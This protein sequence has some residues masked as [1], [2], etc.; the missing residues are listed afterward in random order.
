MKSLRLL[1]VA[2]AVSWAVAGCGG[3]SNPSLAE[4]TDA[5]GQVEGAPRDRPEGWRSNKPGARYH[6][7]D[8]VRTGAASSARLRMAHGGG[9]LAMG[10]RSL[11][12]FGQSDGLQKITLATGEAEI[13]TGD[14][15][16]VVDTASGPAR[17]GAGS[18][19]R[20]HRRGGETH[21]EVVVGT[22]RIEREG[23]EA[24]ALAAGDRVDVSS[25]GD[26][27]APAPATTADAGGADAKMAETP[28]AV[29]PIDAGAPTAP[30]TDGADRA[31][32]PTLHGRAVTIAAPP[33]A[34]DIA[35]PAGETSRV[36][37]ARP[38]AYVRLTVAGLCDGPAVIQVAHGRSRHYYRGRDSVPVTFSHG[39]NRYRV[40]CQTDGA[41]VPAAD[42]ARSRGTVRV[43]RD[44]GRRRVKTRA[45][46]NSVDIDGRTYR[47]LYQNR[48]PTIRFVWPDAPAASK[49][50]LTIT[51]TRGRARNYQAGKPR[52]T[53]PSGKL[54]EGSYRVRMAIPGGARSP[55][56]RVVLDFDNAAPVAQLDAATFGPNGVEVRGLATVGSRV[57]ID[58]VDLPLDDH[59]RFHSRVALPAG[60]RAIAV[61]I[62]RQGGA[63]HYYVRRSPS[64]R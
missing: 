55:E 34:I 52:Y 18:R 1:A 8:G 26:V 63:V 43:L 45:P 31:S 49:Y 62:M 64:K 40:Y 54:A 42:K 12:R 58:G 11:V 33:A 53:L 6:R 35:L 13:E 57:S 24:V 15:A 38:P 22:A 28:A 60:R 30:A 10:A 2:C 20:L 59:Y 61:K 41:L 27:R 14:A 25:S 17:L 7:G 39:R 46:A 50:E 48:K 16:L 47:L 29:I 9:V 5:R 37:V 21:I 51:P 32:G 36:H 4:L 19:V 56:T 44:A 3:S 23:A